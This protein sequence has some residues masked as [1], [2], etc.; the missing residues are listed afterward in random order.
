MI[1]PRKKETIHGKAYT[2]T[3]TH[4][5]DKPTPKMNLQWRWSSQPEQKTSFLL[6]T[7]DFW[8]SPEKITE[9][10]SQI[11]I[12]RNWSPNK[13]LQD[14]IY[15]M[16]QI[17]RITYARYASKN[18]PALK[19]RSCRRPE[20]KVGPTSKIVAFAYMQIVGICLIYILEGLKPPKKYK[21][22]SKRQKNVKNVKKTRLRTRT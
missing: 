14:E 21:K 1:A 16:V 13:K 6:V 9:I 7:W 18:E 22:T 17:R 20:N 11:K 3:Y 2:D 8:V 19:F 5:V 12:L 10:G 15:L 4:A